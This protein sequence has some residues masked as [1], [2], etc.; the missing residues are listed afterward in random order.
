MTCAQTVGIFKNNSHHTL[1]QSA[2]SHLN[3]IE[4]EFHDKLLIINSPESDFPLD[5]SNTWLINIRLVIKLNDNFILFVLSYVAGR[6]DQ[7]FEAAPTSYKWKQLLRL[8]SGK[9]CQL[10]N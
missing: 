6:T 1:I 3:V 10:A 5:T 9:T 2:L 4:S 8:L 7:M